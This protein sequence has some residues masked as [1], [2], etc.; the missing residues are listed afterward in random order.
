MLRIF[1]LITLSIFIVSCTTNK[2]HNQKFI[3]LSSG[4]TVE[5]FF[6][7][8]TSPETDTVFLV[9][10]STDEKILKEE[11]IE[12]DIL[13]IWSE[14]EK[15]ADEKELNEAIIKYKFVIEDLDEKGELEKHHTVKIFTA[16]KMENSKWKIDKIN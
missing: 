8:Y 9:E 16:E 6:E 11:T 15:V 3:K 5:T 10:S 1:L 4:K 2:N 7:K 14:L 13:E 12:R